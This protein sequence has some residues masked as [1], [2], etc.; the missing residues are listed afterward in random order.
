VPAIVFLVNLSL[1]PYLYLLLPIGISRL[2][3]RVPAF[4]GKTRAFA[5]NSQPS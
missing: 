5:E 2:S 3:A 1:C 4:A